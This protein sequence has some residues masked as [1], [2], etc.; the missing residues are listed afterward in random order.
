MPTGGGM[1][2]LDII[3]WLKSYGPYGIIIVAMWYFFY[4]FMPKQYAQINSIIDKNGKSVEDL[5]NNL[6]TRYEKNIS[7]IMESHEQSLK[8]VADTFKFG[9][10]QIKVIYDLGSSSL[11]QKLDTL[12]AQIGIDKK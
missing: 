2:S 1:P 9:L 10:D 3:N 7:S 6:S 4:Q 8:Q 5:A 11:H 12:I